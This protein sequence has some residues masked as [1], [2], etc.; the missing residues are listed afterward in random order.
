MGIWLVLPVAAVAAAL[1]L[2]FEKSRF[3]VLGAFGYRSDKWL[4]ELGAALW[5]RYAGDQPH[6]SEDQVQAAI[7]TVTEIEA[8]MQPEAKAAL[9]GLNDWVDA[10]TAVRLAKTE[11]A[12]ARAQVEDRAVVYV[13]RVIDRLINK[14]RGILPFNSVMLALLAVTIRQQNLDPNASVPVVTGY[15]EDVTIY[16]VVLVTIFTLIF[17]SL[18][19]LVLFLVRWGTIENYAT[20]KSEVTATLFVV[21]WRTVALQIATGLSLLGVVGVSV[22]ALK[23]LHVIT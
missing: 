12:Q 6:P 20:F 19:L 15:L 14:A 9:N 11:R 22:L 7:K 23:S 18:I 1:I 13:E 8:G 5:K 4:G 10:K 16:W 2:Y 17:S 21:R 3:F